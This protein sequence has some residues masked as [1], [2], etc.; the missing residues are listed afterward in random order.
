[1][2]SHQQICY[3]SGWGEQPLNC[4][5]THYLSLS[6]APAKNRVNKIQTLSQRSSFSA[7]GTLTVIPS[8]VICRA[9]ALNKQ[10]ICIHNNWSQSLRY[11]LSPASPLFCRF[12]R[13]GCG[14]ICWSFTR[15][16]FPPTLHLSSL[17]HPVKMIDWDQGTECPAL[18]QQMIWPLLADLGQKEINISPLKSI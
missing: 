7:P 16:V 18:P 12:V 4:N 3:R 9:F 2:A 10:S 11:L 15:S 13:P 1:M 5:T 6:P 17:V 14:C 8:A